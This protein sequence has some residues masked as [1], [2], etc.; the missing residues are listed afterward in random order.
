M[1]LLKPGAE[2]VV[3]THAE[4]QSQFEQ[5]VAIDGNTDP[6]SLADD[7]ICADVIE[8][9]IPAFSDGRGLSIARYLRLNKRYSGLLR[10]TGNVI[11]DQLQSLFQLGFDEVMIGD[12]NLARHSEQ[13]WRD[14]SASFTKNQSLLPNYQESLGGNSPSIWRQRT[15]TL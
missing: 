9:N 11:P 10:V 15:L 6:E 3:L 2:A 5:A 1:L 7:V 8:I 4:R 14:A 12:V 13:D